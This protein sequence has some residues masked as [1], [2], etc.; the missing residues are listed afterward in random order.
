MA[1]KQIGQ[2]TIVGGGSASPASYRLVARDAHDRVVGSVLISRQAQTIGRASQCALVLPG[3]GVSRT[4]A[5]V[6]ARSEGVLIHDENSANGV[7]V[8]GQPISGPAVI[9]PS[10]VVKISGYTLRVEQVFEAS[11]GGAE[12]V[13]DES[14]DQQF[15]THLEFVSG[16][17]AALARAKIVLVGRGGAYDGTEIPVDKVLMTVGRDESNAIALADPSVSRQHAQLRRAVSGDR[18]TV[19]DLRSANGTYLDGQR[20][21]RAE[22]GDGAVVRFGDLA[23]KVRVEVAA[24]AANAAAAR[25]AAVASGRSLKPVIVALAALVCVLLGVIVYRKL[26]AGGGEPPRPA[27]TDPVTDHLRTVRE[28]LALAKTRLMTRDWPGAISVL[29]ELVK[30]EPWNSEA[31]SALEQAKEELN[32]ENELNRAQELVKGGDPESL[33]SARRILRGLPEASAYHRDAVFALKNVDERLAKHLYD[34]G[35]ARCSAGEL[36]RCYADLCRFFTY[37]S[38]GM[39]AAEEA[40]ARKQMGA[41]ERD[42]RIKRELPRCQAQRYVR[43]LESEDL[44]GDPE[45][46]LAARYPAVAARRSLSE[47][48]RGNVDRALRLLSAA[49]RRGAEEQVEQLEEVKRLVL[50][51]RG[52][53]QEGFALYRERRVAEAERAWRV[54]LATDSE[55]MPAELVSFYRKDVSERLA[56]LHYELGEEHFRLGRHE[57][58]FL[59]WQRGRQMNPADAQI[60]GGLFQL[61]KVAQGLIQEARDALERGERSEAKKRLLAARKLIVS[62]SPIKDVIDELLRAP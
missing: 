27:A 26:Q 57:R 16:A 12:L 46:A 56:S 8:N 23:F 3:N 32:N 38:A 20:V 50:R 62:D 21:K 10:S 36:K 49:L 58:A 43:A 54:M 9:D 6:Y 29:D 51:A 34:E 55:L 15:D 22:V 2:E 35:A 45:Q 59:H 39:L 48:Y 5:L 33:R 24:K 14:G 40:N 37:V 25:R 13:Y 28:R 1:A 44:G 18:L 19:L 11:P 60:Q 17:G 52:T 53:Y 61:E 47:Y 42:P 41:L 4:H 31:K 30:D 7:R